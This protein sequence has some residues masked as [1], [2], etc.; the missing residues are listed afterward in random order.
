MAIQDNNLKK[1]L[2]GIHN[3]GAASLFLDCSKEMGYSADLVSTPEDMLTKIKDND[4]CRYLMD[5]N[6]GSPC[7]EDITPAKKSYNLIKDKKDAKFLAITGYLNTLEN[8]KKENI[9][10]R[11]RNDLNFFE[12]LE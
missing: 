6:L 10:C 2:I 5:G 12:F 1:I 7:G 9:P 4:Y 8:L 11:D 3:K